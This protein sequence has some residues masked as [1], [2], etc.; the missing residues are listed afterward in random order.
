M[1]VL[2]HLWESLIITHINNRP[3]FCEDVDA[4]LGFPEVW[5]S[6]VFMCHFN[7]VL[8]FQDSEE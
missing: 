7:C 4:F 6:G 1:C 5:K 2:I 8:I 3:H